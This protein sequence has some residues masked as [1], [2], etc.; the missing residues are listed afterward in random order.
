VIYVGGIMNNGIW[1]TAGYN[2]FL[3]LKEGRLYG[4]GN[5]H[6]GQISDNEIEEGKPHLMAE[7]V[8]SM[9]AG[10]DYSL[11]VTSDGEVKIQGRGIYTDRFPGFSNAKKVYA[12]RERF[13]II[14]NNDE[15]YAFGDNENE[16]IVKY[17]Y[18]ELFRFPTLIENA[19]DR[20][21]EYRVEKEGNRL[22]YA[23]WE[24]DYQ[25][26]RS[27][28]H[29]QR[30]EA[31]QETKHF[32]LAQEEY[33]CANVF[34]TTEYTSKILSE[35]NKVRV[36]EYEDTMRIM[37]TNKEIYTPVKL[38]D[39]GTEYEKGKDY[40]DYV[41]FRDEAE[42]RKR[43]NVPSDAVKLK[44]PFYI[45]KEKELYHWNDRVDE[46]EEPK[47]YLA[48]VCDFDIDSYNRFL[49]SLYNGK[50]FYGNIIALDPH[51]GGY[52]SQDKLEIKRFTID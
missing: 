6:S 23:S 5:N 52:P 41:F 36:R 31:A 45:S 2:H 34:V 50:L 51:P 47:L 44:K 43:M 13:Y 1:I 16:H 46:W 39:D 24:G 49:I 12:D 29:S 17:V 35:E 42:L 20:Y 25:D 33:G 22:A 40:F 48:D 7:N 4:F 8:I 37:R 32:R 18:E 10:D 26:V 28:K 38:D 9:A 27:Y 14:D 21:V 11:Y 15:I 30:E 3:I 19:Q